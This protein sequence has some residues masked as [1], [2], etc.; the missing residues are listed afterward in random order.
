[1]NRK[2]LYRIIDNFWYRLNGQS[3]DPDRI[4]ANTERVLR[5]EGKHNYICK[6]NRIIK[7]SINK[8]LNN[9]F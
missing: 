3:M 7:K 5:Y 2:N 1:M 4:N 8:I 6:I 9:L